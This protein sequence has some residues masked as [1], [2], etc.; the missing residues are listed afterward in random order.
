M[1]RT[2]AE[3]LPICCCCG[4]RV[5]H[6]A[7]FL[8]IQLFTDFW[9]GPFWRGDFMKNVNIGSSQS[10]K[11]F[12]RSWWTHPF[13]DFWGTYPLVKSSFCTQTIT[14]LFRG[15]GVNYNWI[16][17]LNL[18]ICIDNNLT[19]CFLSTTAMHGPCVINPKKEME[20]K[21]NPK[22]STIN[23]WREVE[24]RHC[25]WFFFCNWTLQLWSV[26]SSFCASYFFFFG[27]VHHIQKSQRP[28]VVL[29]S[30]FGDISYRFACGKMSALAEAPLMLIVLVLLMAL[31]GE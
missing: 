8:W 20:E 19:R 12:N 11:R 2:C 10:N 4:Q 26:N 25:D 15:R 28:V 31:Q 22:R 5:P 21:E 6:L 30:L 16:Q 13:V 23:N 29:A 18:H 1:Q 7:Q 9:K 17:V 27:A 3:N 24:R 14:N